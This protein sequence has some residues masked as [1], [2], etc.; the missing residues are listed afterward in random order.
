MVDEPSDVT[1]VKEEPKEEAQEGAEEKPKKSQKK[2]QVKDAP[3]FDFKLFN[4]WSFQGVEVR[5]PGIRDYV[6]LTPVLVP[7]MS[8]GRHASRQFHK[9]NISIVERLMNHMFSPGHRGKRH[10]ITSGT[11][12]GASEHGYKIMLKT[13]L[14]IEKREKKNPL[15]VLVRALENASITEEV[16]SYQIGSIIVRKAVITSPQRRVD[17]ALRLFVQGAYGRKFNKKKGMHASLADEIIS[18]SN[19]SKDSY[20]IAERERLERE[21]SGAR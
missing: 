17:L 10:K 11:A 2:K 12:G 9:S 15:E 16:S 6:N 14:E 18:A 21:A 20:A 1:D 7:R 8:H 3:K 5:D 4:R 19:N 13:F